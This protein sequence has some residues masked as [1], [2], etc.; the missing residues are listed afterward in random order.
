M[1]KQIASLFY[2]GGHE[3]AVWNDVEMNQDDIY[4]QIKLLRKSIDCRQEGIITFVDSLERLEDRLTI[5]SIIEDIEIKRQ[6]YGSLET[7]ITKPYFTNTSSF[8]PTEIGRDVN[9][10]HFF[11]PITLKIVE[12]YLCD[13]VDRNELD[14]IL[15]FLNSLDFEIVD[16]HDNRGYIGNNILFHEISTALKLIEKFD[17][18]TETVRTVY[19][20]LYNGRDIFA[21]ID[22]IGIDVVY[23]ILI[24]LKE[25][26]EDIYLPLCL[27]SALE[28]NILGKKNR[29]SIKQILS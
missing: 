22:I 7:K 1:A 21:I 10:L 20:K 17:Y 5:E 27:K 3:V 4:R 18:T 25:K 11:N 8:S 9:G 16:V 29:T 12:L 13:G 6:I 23:K 28:K 2:I 24:N 15:K 26:D 19:K 14:H